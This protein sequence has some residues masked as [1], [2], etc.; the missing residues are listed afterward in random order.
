M[1]GNV[2]KGVRHSAPPAIASPTPGL[3]RHFHVGSDQSAIA[4]SR[5]NLGCDTQP[6]SVTVRP[7]MM[8]ALFAT[9]PPCD[10]LSIGLTQP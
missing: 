5:I 4:V 9:L 8:M 7:M 3:A 10:G 2:T 6:A 1:S